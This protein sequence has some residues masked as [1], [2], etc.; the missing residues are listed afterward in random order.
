MRHCC[1]QVF[2]QQ[3]KRFDDDQSANPIKT[4]YKTYNNSKLFHNIRHSIKALNNTKLPKS[5]GLKQPK[6]DDELSFSFVTRK[7]FAFR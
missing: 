2:H 5:K 1:R 7:G 6:T 3:N 4:T